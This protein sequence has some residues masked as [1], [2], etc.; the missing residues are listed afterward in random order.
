MNVEKLIE[1]LETQS[2]SYEQFRLFARIIRELA[3]ITG[4]CYHVDQGNIYATKG[5]SHGYPAM[6]AHMDTVHDITDDLVAVQIGR[7]VTGFNPVTMKQTGI[8]GD[9]KVGVFIALECLRSCDV[10][11]AAFFRDEEVGC[12]GSYAANSGFFNDCNFVL[13]CDR[14]GYADFVTHAGCVELSSAEFQGCLYPLLQAHGYMYTHGLMT[15]VMAL[16]EIGVSCSMA[17]LSCGYFAPHTA[18]EF[19][20]L[21]AV[22]RCLRLVRSIFDR[23]GDLSFP[24]RY[25]KPRGIIYSSKSNVTVHHLYCR[26][27]WAPYP[28][29]TGYCN[30]CNEYYQLQ[31]K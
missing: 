14:S 7:N 6:V 21:D 19:V 1:I 28:T 15:D 9:D 18:H 16:K 17:N 25:T 13:Q 8:G 26:D 20:N 2:A 10:L 24:H 22:D 5:R 4:L 30:D 27:C 3:S 11:K 23:Y 29:A 31:V 12:E